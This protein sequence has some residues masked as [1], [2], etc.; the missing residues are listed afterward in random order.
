MSSSATVGSGT[1]GNTTPIKVDD[2]ITTAE[3]HKEHKDG[4]SNRYDHLAQSF[5]KL[6][7]LEK[8]KFQELVTADRRV[9]SIDNLDDWHEFYLDLLGVSR[10]DGDPTFY[11]ADAKT[12]IP[13]VVRKLFNDPPSFSGFIYANAD[14]GLSCSVY[15]AGLFTAS[16][17][18]PLTA[19]Q[20]AYPTVAT[21]VHCIVN[22]MNREN[23][24][25]AAAATES[26]PA[27]AGPSGQNEGQP[28]LPL[29]TPPPMP[30][31]S[32]AGPA[33]PRLH[34]APNHHLKITH[35]RRA[36]NRLDIFEARCDLAVLSSGQ[37]P[38]VRCSILGRG[39]D[40]NRDGALKMMQ[41]F[42]ALAQED[43][44]RTGRL[45]PI[46]GIITSGLSVSLC[47]M[48][49]QREF[50][51]TDFRDTLPPYRHVEG[52]NGPGAVLFAT[53]RLYNNIRDMLNVKGLD[54]EL[55]EGKRRSRRGTRPRSNAVS[56][57]KEPASTTD[58]V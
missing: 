45:R 52:H 8:E 9:H 57:G 3:E 34:M 54:P 30:P 49:E 24:A 43:E 23:A 11:S 18:G 17:K 29:R 13:P 10:T 4:P 19:S 41:T 38:H 26:E 51:H 6:T 36:V 22:E 44:R 55:P 16:T 12:E 1:T 48:N 27:T 46:H 53:T 32:T 31:R 7:A 25:A 33:H 14:W 28:P 5:C 40:E 15:A 47:E 39:W 58:E 2:D 50:C 20:S 21:M 42:L 37:E 35:Y 56:K